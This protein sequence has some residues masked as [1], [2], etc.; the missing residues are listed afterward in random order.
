VYNKTAEAEIY[1]DG[2]GEYVRYELQCRNQY[3][4][5]AFVAL[6][7]NMVR[8]FYLM[9][10]KR[11]VDTFTFGTVKSAIEAS[12]EELFVDDFP[13]NTDDPVERRKRWL[14]RSVF[15]AMRRMLLEDKDYL[16]SFIDRLYNS[17][18]NDDNTDMY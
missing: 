7:N 15:P 17:A 2:G 4:D 10:L 3:A 6:R 8:A 14:E 16:D 13:N 11:M 12:D 18:S 5:R 9:I 1:P